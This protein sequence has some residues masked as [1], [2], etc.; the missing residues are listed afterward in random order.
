MKSGEIVEEGRTAT[1]FSAPAHPYTQSLIEAAPV[2]PEFGGV[3]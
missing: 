3:S 2:L 1:V